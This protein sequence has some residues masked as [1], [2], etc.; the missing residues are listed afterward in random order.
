M[1]FFR[2]LFEICR[3]CAT[4]VGKIELSTIRLLLRLRCAVFAT[5]P[6]HVCIVS[7]LSLCW[8]GIFV[9]V[10]FSLIFIFIFNCCACFYCWLLDVSQCCLLRYTGKQSG[11]TAATTRTTTTKTNKT[12]NA[13]KLWYICAHFGKWR[14][15]PT[16]W[17]ATTKWHVKVA[18][19]K[20][21]QRTQPVLIVR[22]CESAQCRQKFN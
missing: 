21:P 1:H 14:Y 9:V 10:V 6:S 12:V 3:Q 8:L 15:Q 20:G 4:I 19:R 22:N 5:H 18:A 7:L 11:T 2:H 16:Q 13:Y 17:Q